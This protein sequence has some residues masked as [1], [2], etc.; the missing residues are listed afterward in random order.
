GLE[1][2]L[3]ASSINDFCFVD[4]NNGWYVSDDKIFQTTN[5]GLNWS[6]Q[7][8][9]N[10]QELYTVFFRDINNGWACGD[11]GLIL[12]TV[13]GGTP[14]ELLSFSSSVIDDDIT[15]NWTTATETNNSGFEIQR[16]KDLK[17]E[18]LEEWESIGFVNGHGTTTEPQS[19]SFVDE[20]LSSGKPAYRTGRYQYRL[21]QIDFDGTFEYSNIVEAEILPPA[22]FSLEQNYPNPFNPS[23]N[24]QYTIASGQ[25]VSLIVFNSLGEKVE[26]LV[27]EYQEVG[28]HSKLYILNSTLPSGVYYYQLVAGD[29][30]QTRK[31]IIL[32]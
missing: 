12:R 6:L 1:W 9:N 21:K 22:K 24:I 19:Y 27:K 3:S 2:N 16:F 31:M 32:K 14:V 10:G 7:L 11:S 28:V 15:L 25:F 5:A 13:N 17:I 4:Q 23:T 26:T 8:T 29:F 20:N 30:I 18:R